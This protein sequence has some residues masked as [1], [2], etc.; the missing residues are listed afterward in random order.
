MRR[1][2]SLVI[3]LVLTLGF[4]APTFAD[5]N[6]PGDDV[7][8][9]LDGAVLSFDVPPQIVNGRTLVPMRGI[10]E[11]LGA[12]VNWDGDRQTIVATKDDTTVIMQIGNPIMMVGE[13]QVA[14][15][16]PPQIIDDRT[17]VP[18]RAAADAFDLNVIWD[19]DSRMVIIDSI[20]MYVPPSP[21]PA[22][23]GY[24]PGTLTAD[25]YASEYLNLRLPLSDGYTYQSTSDNA[26]DA[27][28]IFKCRSTDL[29]VSN[30]DYT[31]SLQIWVGGTG[32]TET[33]TD[34]MLGII[35]D[36]MLN[37]T[38]DPKPS[39]G[40]SDYDP[41]KPA[42]TATIAGETYETLSMVFGDVIYYTANIVFY[43]RLNNDGN[44]VVIVGDY[45]S[46]Q[47]D[48]YNALLNSFTEY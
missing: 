43:V 44:F 27:D 9:T 11:A 35:N 40:T 33:D 26:S 2:L 48:A 19:A 25:G 36:M 46:G 4:S 31:V 37:S 39:G 42:P 20:P 1:I 30:D 7:T 12:T 13:R 8:V 22:S 6:A 10:F 28:K 32:T 47:T 24:V 41:N 16:V 5:A 29:D 38:E 14:L 3:A 23:N 18:A 21:T 45:T 15:D 17:M 34:D